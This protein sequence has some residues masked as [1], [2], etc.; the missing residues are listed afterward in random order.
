MGTPSP[1]AGL[2]SLDDGGGMTPSRGK[3]KLVKSILYMS[4][5]HFIPQKLP[6]Y[7]G[8]FFPFKALCGLFFFL[9]NTI[10]PVSQ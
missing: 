9:L 3:D 4:P 6:K 8:L 5:D 10:P 1:A 7:L 2:K